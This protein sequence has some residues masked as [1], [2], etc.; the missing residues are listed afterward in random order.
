M[1]HKSLI[2]ASREP[3]GYFFQIFKEQVFN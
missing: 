3:T 2:E 1:G